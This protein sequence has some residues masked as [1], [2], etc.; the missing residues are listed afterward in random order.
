M[1]APPMAG[2]RSIDM[3]IGDSQAYCISEHDY[4]LMEATSALARGRR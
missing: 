2:G 4:E 1:S 3:K